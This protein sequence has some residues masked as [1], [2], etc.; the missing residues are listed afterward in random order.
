MFC[1]HIVTNFSLFVTVL[2]DLDIC[3]IKFCVKKE[4]FPLIP[5]RVS[6]TV[7][8]TSWTNTHTYSFFFFERERNIVIYFIWQFP[9]RETMSLS[10][11]GISVSFIIIK[12]AIHRWTVIKS[13]NRK[14]C[15][16]RWV[17][18]WCWH[19]VQ[20]LMDFLEFL[21]WV[22]FFKKVFILNVFLA[23]KILDLATC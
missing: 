2:N 15:M 23:F 20:I 9:F 19:R 12:H 10:P 6:L 7:I 17:V 11:I 18:D 21:N 14:R 8:V 13:S 4:E 16:L 22:K 3:I 1:I 5:K